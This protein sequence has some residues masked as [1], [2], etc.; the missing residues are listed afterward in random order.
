MIR[1][2]NEKF[3]TAALVL[4]DSDHENF[5]VPTV[6]YILQNR[7]NVSRP[8]QRRLERK[9]QKYIKLSG[10]RD[11][12]KAPS[13]KLIEGISKLPL[14]RGLLLAASMLEVWVLLKEDLHLTMRE[15]LDTHDLPHIEDTDE[16]DSR[17]EMLTEAEFD[18]LIEPFR[19]EYANFEVNEVKLMLCALKNVASLSDETLQKMVDAGFLK[20]SEVSGIENGEEEDLWENWLDELEA[21][22]A[23]APDWK[24]VDG[25]VQRVQEIAKA[26]E[27][28]RAAHTVLSNALESL[29]TGVE[30]ELRYFHMDE[31][32]NWAYNGVPRD[33]VEPLATHVSR[34]QELLHQHHMLRRQPDS[35][36]L[37]DTKRDE[38]KI[39]LARQILDLYQQLSAEFLTHSQATESDTLD[40]E[41][42]QVESQVVS[43]PLPPSEPEPLKEEQI[44][45]PV[46]DT[47]ALIPV[48]LTEAVQPDSAQVVDLESSVDMIEESRAEAQ[49]SIDLPVAEMSEIELATESFESFE[50]A[51]EVITEELINEQPDEVF[52]EIELPE[53][54]VI[55]ESVSD[56]VVDFGRDS[57]TFQTTDSGGDRQLETDV[58]SVIPVSPTE[59]RSAIEIAEVL[60]QDD[61]FEN[62]EA[63]LWAL[64][65]E[66]DLPGAY[67]LARSL[68]EGGYAT[69]VPHWLLAAVQ[70]ARWVS[71]NSEL[72]VPDLLSIANDHQPQANESE[73]ELISLSAALCPTLIAPVSGLVSWLRVS[74]SFPA[75][76]KLVEAISEF[77]KNNIAL[78]PE[79]LLGAAGDAQRTA[80]LNE[81]IQTAKQWL[82]QA[83]N[84][85]GNLGKGSVVWQHLVKPQGDMQALLTPVINDRRQE[86]HNVQKQIKSWRSDEYLESRVNE[87]LVDIA[88]GRPR[89]LPRAVMQM[90]SRSIE[91]ACERAERWGNLVIREQELEA[92]GTWLF[93]QIKV[94]RDSIQ[95]IMP[96]VE[97]DLVELSSPAQNISRTA[98]GRCLWRS[99]EALRRILNLPRSTASNIPNSNNWALLLSYADNLDSALNYRL[100]WMPEVEVDNRGN[101]KLVGKIGL[102]LRDVY[103]QERSLTMAFEKWLEKEDYRFIEEKL[104]PN[105]VAENEPTELPRKFREALEISKARLNSQIAH[106]ETA[107]EQAL[108][109]GIIDDKDR[110]AHSSDVEL[111]KSRTTLNFYSDYEELNNL[112][113]SL[114]EARQRRVS[115]LGEIWQSLEAKLT[116]SKIQPEKQ[117]M[118]Q[119]RV[120]GALDRKDTRVVEEY[121]ARLRGALEAGEELEGGW[122]AASNQESNVL[123]QFIEVV[124]LIE[125]WLEKQ[126]LSSVAGDIENGRSRAG[127]S[128]GAVPTIRLKE[129]SAAI[130]TWRLLK[131]GGRTHRNNQRHVETLV[132][133]LGFEIRQDEADLVN[134]NQSGS[135]W[136]HLRLPLSASEVLARPIPQFGSRALEYSDVI[137]LW[138]RPGADTIA[139]RLQELRLGTQSVIVFFLGRLTTRQRRDLTRMSRERRIAVTVVDEIAIIFLAQGRDSRL[140]IFLRCLLPFTVIN[141]YSPFQAGD[142]P[143]E[144]F[145]GRETMVRELQRPT[146]S[147]LV[148]GGRQLGKSAL[149]R[150]VQRQFN[151]PDREQYA[152]VINMKLIFDPKAGKNTENLWLEIRDQFREANLISPRIRTDKPDEIRRYIKAALTDEPSRR[153]L[154][155]FDEADMFLDKD[156]EDG[157]RVITALRELMLETQ[158]RFKVIFAGLHNVQRFQSI[159]NQPLAHFG[160]PLKIGPLEPT[161]A[162]Q[163]IREPFTTLGYIFDKNISILRILSYTNYHPGLIQLF[164]QEL[165]NELRSSSSETLPP[166]SIEQHHV[167]NV[168]LKVIGNIRE[169]F[170]WTL[171]LDTRYQAIAWTLIWDQMEIRDS[172]A[173]PYSPSDISRLVIEWWPEGFERVEIDEL[174]GLLDEMC[175]LGVLVRNIDGSYRLR[176]PNLVRLIGTGEDIA[177]RLLELTYKKVPKSSDA[178]DH[179]APLDDTARRYSPLTYA[180]ES[181]LNPHG[182]GVGLICATEALGLSMIPQAIKRFIPRDLAEGVG[183]CTEMPLSITTGEKLRNWLNDHLKS[184]SSYERLVVYQ[185]PIGINAKDLQHIIEE[186]VAF[187]NQLNQKHELSQR[188]WI[189]IFFIADPR[190]TQVWL[191]IPADIREKLEMQLDAVE[192]PKCWNLAGI[193]YR[194][195]QHDKL[196]SEAIC[197]EIKKETDGW[198]YLLDLLFERSGNQDDPRPYVKDIRENLL[199]VESEL[200]KRFRESLGIDP[201]SAAVNVL[202]FIE[203]EKDGVPVDLVTPEFIGGEPPL[204]LQECKTAVKYLQLIGCL[205]VEKDLIYV[206][207]VVKR[208]TSNT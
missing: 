82:A 110:A 129:A 23:E 157:F 106:T 139:A 28:E 15:F 22:P 62:W 90:L 97:K 174:R 2:K 85:R 169:R 127:I 78:Q 165:L 142:V 60:Q 12:L 31:V 185:R 156:S 49:I 21:L 6:T 24:G 153:V 172:Y 182:S 160:T 190:T 18:E 30:D 37:A 167:E 4:I 73:L 13:R 124:P 50:S 208:V 180:Q 93:K 138:S 128:F 119:A 186:A 29:Q 66:D 111:I 161:A 75:I 194:L 168:Y 3:L 39:S 55:E 147:C 35:D 199:D 112:N 76:H 5:F 105:L 178:A 42:S 170:D 9:I 95:A 46:E 133:Y 132:R 137:C 173:R 71:L 198:P 171:A 207:P 205:I 81:S 17:V 70:G 83:P 116:A 52:G 154:M 74:P 159:P 118:I 144:M 204:S 77:S 145:F 103:A 166:Y 91:E 201:S 43:E 16:Q 38:E 146:G 64:I 7:K 40:E 134:R 41:L 57:E 48:T 98:A 141:P 19:A 121:L 126:H 59:L 193:K 120:R 92:R 125:E 158:S 80:K 58:T 68:E 149:L 79:D 67:W 36:F 61:R 47:S 87:I 130:S 135:D 191:S 94:L 26:K 84:R 114:V 206:N 14:D 101:P 72:F 151:Y 69:P 163:L 53:D 200:S 113:N 177:T 202:N 176:S 196:D 63:F 45:T 96:D 117:A 102:A 8:I 143:P 195:S 104:L 1:A 86:V 197:E 187:R 203:K 155:M 100:L 140:P 188:Q 183:N 56:T 20:A 162:E 54:E 65:S 11:P 44:E 34:L 27:A 136:L 10:F 148:Y 131:Q 51:K 115:E 123:V 181:R 152:W 89:P 107:I 189:R 150:H 192:V 25:F 99:V 164:C 32:E 33:E 108:I 109:D 175:G 184:H 122:L 88:R 179:H